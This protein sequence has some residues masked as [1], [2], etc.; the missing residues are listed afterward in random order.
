M[1]VAAG[2]AWAPFER[3]KAP[4]VEDF[5][6]MDADGKG[7]VLVLEFC[8]WIVDGEVAAGRHLAAA[9]EAGTPAPATKEA[10]TPAP[11]TGAPPEA[12]F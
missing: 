8:Q 3:L 6:V 9:E 1:V 2:A 4:K 10:G 12:W 11:A 7:M 5:E